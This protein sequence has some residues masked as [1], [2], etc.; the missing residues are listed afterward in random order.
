[1]D[2]YIEKRQN[3]LKRTYGRCKKLFREYRDFAGTSVYE[4]NQFQFGL[5]IMFNGYGTGAAVMAVPCGEEIM[6]CNF[7]KGKTE[8]QPSKNIFDQDI[9][10]EA[11]FG[12]KDFNWSIQIF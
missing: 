12:K 1:M 10:E 9:S 3:V 4:K 8:C 11:A 2:A 5:V 6:L 7:F